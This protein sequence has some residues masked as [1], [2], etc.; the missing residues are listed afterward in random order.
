[1]VP[2]DQVI[3]ADISVDSMMSIYLSM[4]VTASDFMQESDAPALKKGS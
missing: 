2:V 4:G 3:P 1:M